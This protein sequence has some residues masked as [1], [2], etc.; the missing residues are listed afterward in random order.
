M[1]AMTA[2]EIERGRSQQLSQFAC[3]HAAQQIHLEEAVLSMQK[4]RSADIEN[5]APRK[6]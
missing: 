4:T 1:Q 5:P 2:I 6:S 3:R